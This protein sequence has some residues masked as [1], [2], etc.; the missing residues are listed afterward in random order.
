[1]KFNKEQRI[2]AAIALVCI[3]VFLFSFTKKE[4][5][6]GRYQIDRVYKD[7]MTFYVLLDSRGEPVNFYID[8]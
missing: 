4:E 2:L 3:T 7:G 1:M 5:V 8:R 6:S